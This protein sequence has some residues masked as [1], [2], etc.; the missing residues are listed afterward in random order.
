MIGTE[1][2]R[3]SAGRLL[4]AA[5]WLAA[6]LVAVKAYYL[7]VPQSLALDDLLWHATSLAAISYGDVL[8]AACSGALGLAL[9]LLAG[10]GR[11]A[12]AVSY[13]SVAFWAFCVVYAVANVVM[14]GIFG[15]FLTYPLL[16]LVGDVG[17]IRSSVTA[18]ATPGALAAVIG[19][20]A[21]FLLLVE[22]T[23]GFLLP[24]DRRAF[25]RRCAAVVG[26]AALWVLV[27]Y[28][29]YATDWTT[30]ADR[31]IA[32]NPH[33]L[34]ASSWVRAVS[35]DGSVRMSDSVS[36]DDLADFAP[37]GTTSATPA[38]EL[39]SAIVRAAGAVGIRAAAAERGPNVILIVL[40]SV[41]ARWVSLNSRLYDTTPH[42]QAESGRAMVF[43]N[44]YAPIGRSSNSLTTMLMSA[45][46]RLDFRESTTEYPHMPGT[47]IATLFAER[48]YRTAFTT[49]SDLKWAGWSDFIKS[50]GF[51]AVSDYHDL[52]CPDILSSWGVEDRCMVDGMLRE[53]AAE[54][55]R[56]FFLMGWTTQTH[57]P[58]EPSP[59]V[60]VLNLVKEPSPDDYELGRYLNVLHETDAQLGRIFDRLRQTGLDANTLVVVT[61]DH[62]Q[63]FGYPHDTYIQ[64]RTVYQE[65]VNVPLMVWFPKRFRAPVRS[66]VV[67]GLIDLP[68]TIAELAGFRA[69]P[70][71]Q[72][73]SLL[74]VGRSGRAYFYV[75][76]DQ[77]TLGVRDGNWKY[78]LSLREGA[79]EL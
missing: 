45:Y 77:F 30:R 12:V 9:V 28:G 17:M 55:G 8:F 54:P 2:R 29:S 50:H 40:E 33:W 58:Y 66:A 32:E 26:I 18:H 75:A 11:M 35:G 34:L 53:I 52:G 70:D 72:G 47:S 63:A 51:A 76:E 38:R 49:P 65:D 24:T 31:R 21:A 64:G 19:L 13:A 43:D 68:P 15:G 62:G 57:H 14:F 36:A 69:A 23:K 6:A 27:G 41:A 59:G 5:V 67:G 3:A 10:R 74:A 4:I 60:P 25:R 46:P 7:G 44:V 16:A 48:G 79:E 78:I 39:K 71:W 73:R 37:I 61:G 1:E 56:P 42:L 20:P 22:T